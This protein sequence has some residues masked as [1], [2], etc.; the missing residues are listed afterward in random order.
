MKIKNRDAT[1]KRRVLYFN[2]IKKRLK[3]AIKNVIFDYFP[4]NISLKIEK[5]IN[6][7]NLLIDEKF[8]ILKMSI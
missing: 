7:E 5:C 4:R 6:Y 1:L 3:I 2:K 8:M